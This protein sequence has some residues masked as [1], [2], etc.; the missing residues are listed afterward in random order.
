MAYV[1]GTWRGTASRWAANPDKVAATL[2]T[3]EGLHRSAAVLMA[4]GTRYEA[5]EPK[6][7]ILEQIHI[8]DYRPIRF[9]SP[10]GEAMT[11][12]RGHIVGVGAGGDEDVCLIRLTGGEVQV[13][14]PFD[15]L[16][17]TILR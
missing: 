5:N 6:E 10:G 17:S 8:S 14:C 2:D 9:L 7:A 4:D 15:D 1:V 16:T 13:R 12:F 3:G 11:I